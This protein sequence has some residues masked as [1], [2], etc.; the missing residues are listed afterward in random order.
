MSITFACKKILKGDLIRCSFQINKTSYNTLMV[1]TG[2]KNKLRVEDITKKIGLER[3]GVQKA[4]KELLKKGLIKRSQR[5]LLNGGYVYVY[6]AIDKKEIK[7]RVR[8]L[9][10]EWYKSADMEIERL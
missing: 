1:L 3:S 2:E 5:N 4:V 10:Y 9:L 8:D 7:K 6:S